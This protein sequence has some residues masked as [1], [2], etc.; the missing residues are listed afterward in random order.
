MKKWLII[1]LVILT[2]GAGCARK[3]SWTAAVWAG[4][5]EMPQVN[6]SDLQEMADQA[7]VP[8]FPADTND[9]GDTPEKDKTQ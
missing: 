8:E 4:Q 5:V 6:I 7:V 9:Q 1:L 3:I 2:L